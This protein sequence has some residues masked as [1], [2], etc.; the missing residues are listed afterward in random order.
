MLNSISFVKI[1]RSSDGFS[2]YSISNSL[3]S[4]SEYFL[5]HGVS[6]NIERAEHK[7]IKQEFADVKSSLEKT[8]E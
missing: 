7:C 1:S 2:L 4:K 6:V 5:S 8:L 3:M